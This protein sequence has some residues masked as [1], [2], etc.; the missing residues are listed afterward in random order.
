ME[1]YLGLKK[2]LGIQGYINI[3]AG[4]H[5]SNCINLHSD[6]INISCIDEDC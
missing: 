2:K 3:P 6:P 4:V 5:K 1:L